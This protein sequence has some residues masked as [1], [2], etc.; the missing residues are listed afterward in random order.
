[1]QRAMHAARPTA[2]V[3]SR[4]R[5]LLT[6]EGWERW[7][8]VRARNGLSRYVAGWGEDGPLDA[9]REY[10]QTVD[11]I[12]RRIEDALDPKPEPAADADEPEVL[13]A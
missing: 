12:P 1:M 13:A 3:S 6:T 10:A 2:T 9:I 5:A 8:T 4:P 11:T 7:I